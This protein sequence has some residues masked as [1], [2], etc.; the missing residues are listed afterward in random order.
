MLLLIAGIIPE[1]DI[2]MVLNLWDMDWLAF[3]HYCK[4]VEK[5]KVT[6]FRLNHREDKI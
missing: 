4:A 5:G 3:I 6:G 1:E 2:S